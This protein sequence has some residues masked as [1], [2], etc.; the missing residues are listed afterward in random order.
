MVKTVKPLCSESASGNFDGFLQF[1]TKNG[2]THVHAAPDPHKINQGAAS[3]A[4]GT[5]RAAYAQL[6]ATWKAMDE[7]S[8]NAYRQQAEALGTGAT[9][10][11]LFIKQGLTGVLDMSGLLFSN[12]T[13]SNQLGKDGEFCLDYTGFTFYG[14]KAGGVWGDGKQIETTESLAAA[15]SGLNLG[16]AATHDAGDFATPSSVS[17][18]ISALS[19]KSASTHEATDFATAAQGQKADSAVQ[20]AALGTAAA[21]NVGYFATAA[22]GAKADNLSSNYIELVKG[23]G[24][25]LH[26][27]FNETS[28]TSCADISGFENT[29][30]A[31]GTTIVDGVKGKARSFNG[32]SDYILCGSSKGWLKF[33]QNSPFAIS[34]WF[35]A[36]TFPTTG[37]SYL[38][39]GDY[40]STPWNILGYYLGINNLSG[41]NPRAFFY[42]ENK[43]VSGITCQG[44][45]ILSTG[46]WYSLICVS[47][48]YYLRFYLNGSPDSTA[49]AN[50]LST[51]PA[52]GSVHIGRYADL[53]LL[54]AH[55]IIDD[56][57]IFNRALSSYEVSA[58]YNSY[59]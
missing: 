27:D 37:N 59:L 9:G 34:C 23:L 18:A 19:L 22:Q 42:I 36:T 38:L 43:N 8:K 51:S 25:V 28:G 12:G 31:T 49:V 53:G 57:I 13:P 54:Y 48:G 17:G 47:N 11:N 14:P 41:S 32:S 3:E 7:A 24:Q 33:S 5:V 6:A 44:S 39:L 1:R 35:K 16:S 50:T 20:P 21:Q 40:A 45:T 58:L 2:K 15:L 4:Q 29:A 52:R 55:G 10:W 46:T 56:P 30:T 26:L